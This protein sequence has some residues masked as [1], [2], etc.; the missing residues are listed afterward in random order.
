MEIARRASEYSEHDAETLLNAL[1]YPTELFHQLLARLNLLSNMKFTAAMLDL[2][3]SEIPELYQRKH[4]S[5]LIQQLNGQAGAFLFDVKDTDEMKHWIRSVFNPRARRGASPRIHIAPALRVLSLGG[6]VQS[7]VMCLM[8]DR[9]MFR[10]SHTQAPITPD[11]AVFSDTDWEPRSVYETVEWIRSQVS[12]PVLTVSNGRS[13]RRDVAK[14]INHQGRPWLNIPVFLVNEQG[15]DGRNNWRQC[16]MNYKVLPIQRKVRQMLGVRVGRPVPAETK[17]EMWLG[18]SADEMQRLKGSNEP[19]IEHR[20][21]LV[22]DIPMGREDC[23]TW[24][25]ENYPG[26]IL[27]RSACIGCPF[28]NASSWVSV[29]KSDPVGFAEAVQIDQLFRDPNHHIKRMFRGE[30]YLHSRRLPLA[31]AVE[32]DSEEM[33]NNDE[34]AEEC[35]GHCGV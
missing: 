28:R 4:L 15:K 2:V 17:V 3:Q 22:E 16:T 26:R 25:R 24:F 34:F 10:D 7:T 13:L 31:E 5:P 32:L 20:F 33:S 6:G 1:A 19:W 35:G 8:A 27:G 12:F 21:P 9:G 30:V 14:G 18:I 23:L 29:R 11:F